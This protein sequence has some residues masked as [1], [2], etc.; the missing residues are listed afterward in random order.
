MKIEK[1][2]I[3]LTEQFRDVSDELLFFMDCFLSNKLINSQIAHAD[4]KY[5]PVYFMDI[6]L[7]MSIVPEYNEEEGD[8]HYSIRFENTDKPEPQYYNLKLNQKIAERKELGEQFSIKLDEDE[9]VIANPETKYYFDDNGCFHQEFVEESRFLRINLVD[10]GILT[11]KYYKEKDL[12]ETFV[13][14]FNTKYGIDESSL[15]ASVRKRMAE[16][17]AFEQAA[18]ESCL[19]ELITTHS[20]APAAIIATLINYVNVP[21]VQYILANEYYFKEAVQKMHHNAYY[22]RKTFDIISPTATN[23][24]EALKIDER[25]ADLI[26]LNSGDEPR[27]LSSLMELNRRFKS[28]DTLMPLSKES[29]SDID[30]ILGI[31]VSYFSGGDFGI[32]LRLVRLGFSLKDIRD[33]LLDVD[34]NQAIERKRALQIM[35]TCLNYEYLMEGEYSKTF[36]TSLKMRRDILKRRFSVLAGYRDMKSIPQ[37][38]YSRIINAR[39]DLFDELSSFN[40]VSVSQDCRTSLSEINGGNIVHT[41]LFRE[42]KKQSAKKPPKELTMMIS[43]DSVMRPTYGNV[44]ENWKKDFIIWMKRHGLFS[45]Q[46]N[47]NSEDIYKF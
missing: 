20:H 16:N 39:S 9:F 5:K 14:T 35:Y 11:D 13:K 36:P 40:V 21:S 7:K 25:W 34:T 1:I 15:V 26:M 42:N 41:V 32:L 28:I 45:Q 6:H 22:M 12:L 18:K 24:Q 3:T 2:K 33:Y 29:A 30:D 4:A 17:K 47:F 10:K 8:T 37:E 31:T 43:G 44:P 27:C 46:A 38:V 19:L 23:F